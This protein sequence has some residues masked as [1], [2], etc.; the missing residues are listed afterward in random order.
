MSGDRHSQTEQPELIADDVERA[1]REAEN[2]IRQFNLA[3]EIVR[4]HVK[5]LERPFRL[6]S[7]LILQLHDA[8]LK[9]VHHLAGTFRNTPVAIGGSKHTP[10]EAFMVSDEVHN[11]CSYV[12]DNWGTKSATHLGAYV[13]W[14]LNW[15]HPFADG[16]GRTSRAISYVVMSIKLDSILPGT[17]TIPDQIASDKAPYYN[18]LEIADSAWLE[19][20]QVDVSTLEQMLETMLARQLLSATREAVGQF[21]ASA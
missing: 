11:L 7:Y 19:T 9:G 2:G 17:P 4:E 6:R 18:A 20:G 13:L 5:D 1:R 14:R 10:P 8:A 21:D 3:L 16:N 12:N 15:I